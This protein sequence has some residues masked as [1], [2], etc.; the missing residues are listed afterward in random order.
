MSGTHDSWHPRMLVDTGR[1]GASFASRWT[2]VLGL[3][4]GGSAHEV[5]GA[6]SDSRFGTASRDFLLTSVARERSGRCLLTW[7]RWLSSW[8][9][10]R[11]RLNFLT[12]VGHRYRGVDCTLVALSRHEIAMAADERPMEGL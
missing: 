3:F 11:L 8:D 5:D 9:R 7:S 6:E 2:L 4:L 12:L 10:L 1:R